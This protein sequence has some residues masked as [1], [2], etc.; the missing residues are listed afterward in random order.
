MKKLEQT[1]SRRRFLRGTLKGGAVSVGLPLLN[2]FLNDNGTAYA[3]GMPIP[4][5]FGTWSWGL[6]MSE[7]IDP[8][9]VRYQQRVEAGLASINGVAITPLVD[10]IQLGREMIQFRAQYTA[11]A[12]RRS[13]STGN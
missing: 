11:E 2:V 3:D 9:Q 10:T 6:G 5:R 8:E 7:S 12:I 1:L 13:L 4:L